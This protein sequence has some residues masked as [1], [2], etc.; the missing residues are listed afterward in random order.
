MK[1]QQ[2]RCFLEVA[3]TLNFTKAAENLYITQP[4]LS[5]AIK[6]LE[7]ELGA[8]LFIREKYKPVVITPYGEAFLPH[9]EA[10]FRALHTGKET[11]RSMLDQKGG[12]VDIAYIFHNGY[13]VVK[14]IIN[15]FYESNLD[16]TDDR[17]KIGDRASDKIKDRSDDPINDSEKNGPEHADG[18][19]GADGPTDGDSE[20]LIHTAVRYDT[21]S[22]IE[23]VGNGKFD[24]AI[25]CY[26]HDDP[27]TDY[28]VIG[29]QRL[30][31][32]LNRNHVLADRKIIRLDD[33]R[34]DTVF[35]LRT[36]KSLFDWVGAM[37]EKTCIAPRFNDEYD[38]W[39]TLI[40][41]VASGRGVTIFP[42]IP[43]DSGDLSIIPIEHP[44]NL[45]NIHLIWPAYREL[46]NPA[47]TFR[48]FLLSNYDENTIWD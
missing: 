24:M 41:N 25:S 22:L 36:S 17:E 10:V 8:P 20:I 5:N 44:D 48:Q 27:L 23:Q 21:E 30:Y 31:C 40:Q 12:T 47:K 38:D 29:K 42:R 7:D 14:K 46:T 37:F 11:I 26:I 1:I 13:Y 18:R 16:S 34:N 19:N 35:R 4:S 3:D 43:V 39:S 33:L 32:M 6:Q 9:A 45:R 2:L 15:D 28:A